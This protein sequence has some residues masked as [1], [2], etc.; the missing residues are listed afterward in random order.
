MLLKKVLLEKAENMFGVM[1]STYYCTPQEKGGELTIVNWSEKNPALE[2]RRG[3]V[4]GIPYY[5]FKTPT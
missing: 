5:M 2:K 1:H 4:A 3:S